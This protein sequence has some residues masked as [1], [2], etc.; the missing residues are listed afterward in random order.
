MS[1]KDEF[2]RI[3]AVVLEKLDSEFPKAIRLQ[4]EG[5]VDEADQD[6]VMI[7]CNTIEFLERENLLS[8]DSAADTG[9]LFNGVRLTGKGL[10]ALNAVPDILKEKATF[11]QHITTALRSG[12]K[13]VIKN[14][15]NQ[16]I[17]AIATGRFDL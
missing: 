7:F 12:S 14:A 1:N 6:A 17:Q 9:T 2:N 13:E 8:Y 4:A 15:I 5:I 16:L 11:R 10:A 3:A